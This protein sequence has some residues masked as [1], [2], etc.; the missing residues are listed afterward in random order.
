MGGGI[1]GMGAGLMDMHAMCE[2]H[3]AMIC[4]SILVLQV[5]QYMREQLLNSKQ[6]KCCTFDLNQSESGSR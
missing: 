2:K 6:S 3:E 1:S 4:G 5:Y